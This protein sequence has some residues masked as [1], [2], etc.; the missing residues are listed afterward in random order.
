MGQQ[1]WQL[2]KE[3]EDC[4]ATAAQSFKI[5]LRQCARLLPGLNPVGVNGPDVI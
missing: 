2:G 1:G 4:R 5:T 3:A